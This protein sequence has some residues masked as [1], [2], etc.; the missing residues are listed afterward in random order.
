MMRDIR[1]RKGG[2]KYNEYIGS[3]CIDDE[4]AAGE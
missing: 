4:T 2:S 3:N 1:N